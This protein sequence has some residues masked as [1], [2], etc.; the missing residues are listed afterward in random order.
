MKRIAIFADATWNS[1]QQGA[2]TNVL[3]MARAVRPLSGGAEQVAFYDWG[4]GSDRKKIAG[5]ISGV[6]SDVGG[7]YEERGLSDCAAQWMIRE[8]GK[9]GFRFESHLTRE[10]VPDSGDAQH[11]ERKGIYRARKTFVRPVSGPVH[12]T[13]KARWLADAHG[14][15]KKSKALGQLLDSV[16]N[17]WSRIEV[18]R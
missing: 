6:H 8:A 10:V 7:G 17:D 3:Q 18:I 12:K 13:V 1:P 5:G 16:N 2:A 15:R 9:S 14:Y 11:N 4:V